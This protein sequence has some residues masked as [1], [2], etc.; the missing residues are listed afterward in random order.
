[1][2]LIDDEG[3]PLGFPIEE[4]KNVN[5]EKAVRRLIDEIGS[6]LVGGLSLVGFFAYSPKLNQQAVE[7]LLA[8]L[9]PLGD[10]INDNS[11]FSSPEVF[12]FSHTGRAARIDPITSDGRSSAPIQSELYR[13]PAELVASCHLFINRTFFIEEKTEIGEHD[14]EPSMN[15]NVS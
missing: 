8:K 11:E 10:L 14:S 9:Q 1:M 6:N 12:L 2:R 5:L 15:F 7:R 3:R 13:K 4:G